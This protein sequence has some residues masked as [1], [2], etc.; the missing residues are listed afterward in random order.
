VAPAKAQL[1]SPRATRRRLKLSPSKIFA[2]EAAVIDDEQPV[3]RHLQ[4]VI[5]Q[6]GMPRSTRSES[7]TRS[8]RY[9]SAE[10]GS[11]SSP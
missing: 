5:D 10:F 1:F 8:P 3:D 6:A 11:S 4:S 9:A 2:A 7:P